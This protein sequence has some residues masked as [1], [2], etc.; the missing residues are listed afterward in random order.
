MMRVWGLGL[1]SV[2]FSRDPTLSSCIQSMKVKRFKE[3]DRRAGQ[4]IFGCK[5]ASCSALER[6][7][8]A[9][10]GRTLSLRWWWVLD[11]Y[12]LFNFMLDLFVVCLLDHK[13]LV[14]FWSDQAYNEKG[15]SKFSLATACTLAKLR[16]LRVANILYLYHNNNQS[17]R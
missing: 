3:L 17:D 2:K 16:H 15:H 1:I 12:S 6:I 10:L 8:L 9:R 11:N 4:A 5:L 7:L 14:K 13:K